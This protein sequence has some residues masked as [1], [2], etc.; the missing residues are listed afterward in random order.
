MPTAKDTTK[1]TTAP[2][3][4]AAKPDRDS[5]PLLDDTPP[6]EDHEEEAA[7]QAT[8]HRRG[9]EAE[10][11]LPLAPDGSVAGYTTVV[12]VTGSDGPRSQLEL[13]RLG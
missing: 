13:D 5:S 6:M 7:A 8:A 10:Q 2:P 4:Q 3:K 11:V 12:P 1:D 9:R